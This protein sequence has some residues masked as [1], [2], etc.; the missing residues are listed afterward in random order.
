MVLRDSSNAESCP[1]SSS[2]ED[3]S[4]FYGC[5]SV[6]SKAFKS[7]FSCGCFSDAG[8]Y[9]HASEHESFLKA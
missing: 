7:G 2:S 3:N 9:K 6:S 1:Q 8:M 5:I 4:F